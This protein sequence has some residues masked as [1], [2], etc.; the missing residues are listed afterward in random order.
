MLTPPALPRRSSNVPFASTERVWFGSSVPEKRYLPSARAST[1]T[2]SSAVSS[3]RTGAFDWRSARLLLESLRRRAIGRVR[4]GRRGRRRAVA[5]GLSRTARCGGRERLRR[6]CGGAAAACQASALAPV[7]L[8]LR[9][10]RHDSGRRHFDAWGRRLRD[11]PAVARAA[12]T[13]KS[14]EQT[15]ITTTTK[16]ERRQP[17]DQSN[18]RAVADR[19]P[20]FHARNVNVCNRRNIA[21]RAASTGGAGG[22]MTRCTSR[23]DFVFVQA[24]IAGVLP[25]KALREY[26]RREFVE[27]LFLDRFQKPGRDSQFM[28]NLVQFEITPAPFPRNVSP[29]ELIR[30]VS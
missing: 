2:G 11:R 28:G 25:H 20:L 30:V 18:R 15:S 5:A 3:S 8:G 27:S 4:G 23:G 10:R 14:P 16:R 29:M 24:E 17:D 21:A 6:S 9:L 7:R 22:S 19:L 12:R 26:A 1:Q 13:H